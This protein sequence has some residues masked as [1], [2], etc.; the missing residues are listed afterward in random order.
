MELKFEK[1]YLFGL[2]SHDDSI[3]VCIANIIMTKGFMYLPGISISNPGF[4]VFGEAS[5]KKKS[6][7][8]DNGD[9]SGNFY[10]KINSNA[11]RNGESNGNH[12]GNGWNVYELLLLTVTIIIPSIMS[13]GMRMLSK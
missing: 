3:T 1:K 2:L 6:E 12:N 10:A 9:G 5:S 13:M 11:N 8:D 4:I 7:V